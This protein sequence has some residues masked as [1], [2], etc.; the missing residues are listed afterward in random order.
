MLTGTVD[1]R[2]LIGTKT[3]DGREGEGLGREL[4]TPSGGN[5]WFQNAVRGVTDEVKGG[6]KFV[7]GSG[8]GLMMD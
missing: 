5:Y 4:C 1:E 8:S 2:W 3:G 6:K 7:E